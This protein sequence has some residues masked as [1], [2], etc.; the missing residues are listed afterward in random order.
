MDKYIV[1]GVSSFLSDI[2]DVIHANNG[3]VYKIF[4]N[5]D[6]IRDE[7]VLPLEK[8]LALLGYP[9]KLFPSLENFE[10]ESGCKYVLGF[11]VVKKH[12]LVGVLKE[13]HGIRM[14]RLIHPKAFLG[15]NVRLGE[16]V[17]INSHAVIS[18]NVHLGDHC[19]IQKN[20]YI[21]HDVVIGKFTRLG[22]STAIAGSCR[23]GNLCSVGIGACF[24]DRIHV[25]DWTVIGAGSLVTKDLPKGVVA[26]GS[27]CKII[28]NNEDMDDTVD[29]S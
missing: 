27:P 17:V 25:G 16:G 4:Q 3:V 22:P 20:V 1:F 9:V 28:R 5:M 7:R 26:V 8:R 11:T 24:L 19:M 29:V 2:I 13:R 6:E 14:D 18:P 15:S 23:I 10:P 12:D 21:G